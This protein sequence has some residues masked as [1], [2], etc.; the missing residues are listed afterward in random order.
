LPPLSL[1]TR[2][3]P[4]FTNVI[5]WPDF[6]EIRLPKP[7]TLCARFAGGEAGVAW[8]GSAVRTIPLQRGFHPGAPSGEEQRNYLGRH[9]H[10]A[11]RARGGNVERLGGRAAKRM[12]LVR[13]APDRGPATSKTKRGRAVPRPHEGRGRS[14]SPPVGLGARRGEAGRTTD[15]VDARRT[16][17]RLGAQVVRLE[18]AGS[19]HAAARRDVHPL[20]ARALEIRRPSRRQDAEGRRRP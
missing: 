1:A 20:Q 17:P 7:K 6:A 5:Q 14:F 10:V 13:F 11:R 4:I 19:R 15:A 18:D 3:S 16:R 9:V 2:G 8:R 12:N